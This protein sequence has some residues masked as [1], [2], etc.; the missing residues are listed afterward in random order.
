MGRRK[1]YYKGLA[2]IGIFL[3]GSGGMIQSDSFVRCFVLCTTSGVCRCIGLLAMF[4]MGS[5]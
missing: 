2:M 1:K 3:T 5:A 4:L